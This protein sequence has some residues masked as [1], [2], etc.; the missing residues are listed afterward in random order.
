L[1]VRL[2]LENEFDLIRKD[3]SGWLQMQELPKV[4]SH[5]LIA[6]A[7]FGAPLVFTTTFGEFATAADERLLVDFGV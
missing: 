3:S 4:H 2:F 5:F 7:F 6:C 1:A